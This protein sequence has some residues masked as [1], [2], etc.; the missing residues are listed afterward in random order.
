M[1]LQRWTKDSSDADKGQLG[2]LLQDDMDS[3]TDSSFLLD[4]IW[5]VCS[6]VVYD[7]G[8]SIGAKLQA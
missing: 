6:V 8:E 1:P 2:Q 4:S 5:D 3:I 7:T